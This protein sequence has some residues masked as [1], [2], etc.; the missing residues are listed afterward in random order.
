MKKVIRYEFDVNDDIANII[1][2]VLTAPGLRVRYEKGGA[3]PGL[4]DIGDKDLEDGLDVLPDVEKKII[5]K[6][7][8]QQKALLDISRD[9]GI[10]PKLLMG[11]IKAIRERLV[12]YV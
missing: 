8:V 10:D 12:F 9:L 2:A 6:F 5:E 11:H 4:K 3:G 1:D 7:F